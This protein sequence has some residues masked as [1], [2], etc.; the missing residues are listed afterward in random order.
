MKRLLSV[1]VVAFAVLAPCAYADS[2]LNINITYVTA[3]MG[4]N[5]A[6][7]NISFTLIG[8]G[9]NITG[10]GGMAC[11]AWCQGPIPDLNSVGTSQVFVSSFT[12]ALVGGTAYDPNSNISLCCIFSSSGLL[13]PSASGFVGSGETFKLLNLTLPSG[14]GWNL[15]FAFFPASGGNPAYYVFVNGT[16]TAGTPPAATPE[17][18]TLGLM[19]T[20]LVGIVGA[21]RRKRLIR[22]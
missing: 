5:Y 12:S 19:A 7:D 16:F 20:G 10:I 11:F 22:R 2:I 13:N 1:V 9:T 17:P 18:G 8:P 21:I 4:P 3:Y 15:N 6:G 14:G